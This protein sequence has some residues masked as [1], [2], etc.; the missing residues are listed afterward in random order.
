MTSPRGMLGAFHDPDGD[1]NDPRL[2][3]PLTQRR[4]ALAVSASSPK[5]EPLTRI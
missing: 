5:D 1:R 3:T 4:H 2:P